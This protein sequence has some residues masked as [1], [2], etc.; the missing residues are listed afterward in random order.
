MRV[1]SG[2]SKTRALCGL[3]VSFLRP[4]VQER[5]GLGASLAPVRMRGFGREIWWEQGA[6]GDVGPC[7]SA[8]DSVQ[9]AL[10][11][12]ATTRVMSGTLPYCTN[13]C[14]LIYHNEHICGAYMN[15]DCC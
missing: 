14:L 5:E 4:R 7:L 8:R 3:G 13:L 12:S 1:T 2:A 15:Y 9:R 6:W 11:V 10:H